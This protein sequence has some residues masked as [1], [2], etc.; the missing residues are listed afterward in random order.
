[1]R[2]IKQ[3]MRLK[4]VEGLSDRAIAAETG[5]S[6]S[7]VAYCLRRV[8]QAGLT[9]PLPKYT[10]EADIDAWLFARSGAKS[11]NRRRTAPNWPVL[12]RQLVRRGITLTTLWKEYRRRQPDG[13]GYARFCELYHA[14]EWQLGVADGS[15]ASGA[16]PAGYP[17]IRHRPV[18]SLY[19]DEV[20][21]ALAEGYS[22]KAVAEALGISRT[23]VYNIAKAEE[24]RQRNTRRSEA[25]ARR[26]RP[27]ATPPRRR[28]AEGGGAEA[29]IR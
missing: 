25:R 29:G 21:A 3:V 2:P 9:W 5:I 1:M 14:Y 8:D 15:A 12:Y 10:R 24:E 7:S 18:T 19:R 22:R 13:Y 23:T 16:S 27:P 4:F 20:I 6:R 11:G 26:M 28:A 17:Y